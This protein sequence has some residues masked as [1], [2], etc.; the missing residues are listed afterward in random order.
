MKRSIFRRIYIIALISSILLSLFITLTITNNVVV[1][2]DADINNSIN[3]DDS[4]NFSVSF[5]EE[6]ADDCVIAVLKEEYSSFNGISNDLSDKLYDLSAKSIED[7]SALS[8]DI[9]DSNCEIDNT[10]AP[11]LYEYYSTTPFTQIIKI[12]LEQPGEQNVIDMINALSGIDEISSASPNYI[13]SSTSISND[14][15]I[16][17]QWGL[18]G[19]YGIN[20]EEAWK[21]TTG[22]YDVR[23]GVIDSGIASHNDLNV[24]VGEGYDFYNNN[25]IT[26]DDTGGHGTHV[27]GII[28]AVGNNGIGISGVAPNVMLV[29]LQTAYNTSGSGT[30]KE[31]DIIEAISYATN[32]WDTDERI[33]ILNCSLSGYGTR[34]QRLAAIKNY[35]GLFVWSAGNSDEDVDTYADIEQFSIPNLI[36]VGA[37]KSNGER[38]DEQ[39]WGDGSGSNYSSSAKYVDIYAPGDK[40]YSTIPNNSYGYMSGTSMAAP[41]VTGTAALLLSINPDLS[42]EELKNIIL[43]SADDITIEGKQTKLLNSGQAAVITAT[44]G[45][46]DISN[47]GKSG[48][49]W[50]IKVEN[51]SETTVTVYYNSKMCFESDAKNW[52]SLTDIEYVSIAAGKSTTLYISENVFATSI[53]L[54]YIFDDVRYI[55]YANQLLSSGGMNVM[56]STSTF[57]SYTQNG[58]T[59][60]IVGKND[61]TWLIELTNNTGSGRTFYY[62]SKM[63][64]EGDAKKWTSLSD[65]SSI[66]L[67]NGKTTSKPIEISENGLATSIAISYMNDIY[68]KIFYA[69]NLNAKGTMSAYA[70]TIDTTDSSDECVA[71]GTLIALA[72]GSQVPVE[73][74]T[75]NE[76]LL[77]WNLYTGTFDT[78]PILC[79][80]SDPIGHYEVIQLSFSDGTTVDV[81]S[82]HGFWD[83]DLNEYVYLDKYA[84]E[85]IGHSFL[86]QGVNGMVE[87]TLVDVEISTEVTT[88]YSP[89]TYGHLCYFVNGMLSMPGGIDGLFNIFE[90]DADTM[91]YDAEAM[92][93]DIEM[94]GLYTYEELNALVSVTEVMFDAVNGQYL[95]VAV[96]KGIITIEQIGEFIEKYSYLF[97]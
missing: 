71:A 23:V 77:V 19:D 22:S 80:D 75:G 35:P 72:D 57:Y 89:V 83:V 42:G 27:A 54:S 96:G 61:S 44:G 94:Y 58:I 45:H 62:N 32:L 51:L 30:H 33:S 26:T 65:V 97:E 55:T 20:V 59:T 48:S 91:M 14:T 17:N 82:E 47:T 79:I 18:V 50:K 8:N 41:H 74:L 93:A 70:N 40:I 68:R 76:M 36:S 31:E 38:P 67:A 66:Y 2:A 95:K 16:N 87:V 63:C 1:L 21:L 53:A 13:Y 69:K 56:Y 3:Y 5:D 43:D 78:A 37:I 4:D 24:N 15:Y 52:T 84:A 85:Y 34:L 11:D 25:T 29:P 28:G 9:L 6:F 92:A 10:K 81:I 39:D 7:L 64:F 86:K 90:V 46:L 49:S 73:D 88:A 60:S 12:E